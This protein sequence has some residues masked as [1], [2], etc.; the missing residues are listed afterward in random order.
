[1]DPDNRRPVDYDI[2]RALLAELPGLTA[3]QVWERIED[4]LPKLWTIYHALRTR[5]RYPAAFGDR[6]AYTP[7]QATGEKA[8]HL[9]AYL[10]GKSV[11]VLAPRLVWRLGSNWLNTQIEIPAGNWRNVLSHRK[12]HGGILEVGRLLAEFPVALLVKQ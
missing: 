9:L 2:R 5:R 11:A 10:R 7:L 8:A 12:V 1:V 6:G 4:G 3:R